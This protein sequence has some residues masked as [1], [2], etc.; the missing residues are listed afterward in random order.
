MTG[1]DLLKV[2]ERMEHYDNDVLVLDAGSIE[3]DLPAIGIFKSGNGAKE[4][5]LT[6]SRWTQQDDKFTLRNI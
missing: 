6:A 5:C 4:R 1:E 3:Q 2:F